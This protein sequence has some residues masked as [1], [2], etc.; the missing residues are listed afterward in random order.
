MAIMNTVTKGADLTRPS[1]SLGWMFPAMFA[2][3][4][5]ALVMGVGMWMFEK[6]KGIASG[7]KK[8]SGSLETQS[9]IGSDLTM[10]WL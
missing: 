4:A 9:G 5:L 7:T 6:G 8:D 2:V 1:L 10:G 3:T